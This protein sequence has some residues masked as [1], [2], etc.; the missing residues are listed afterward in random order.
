MLTSDRMGPASTYLESECSL[1]FTD[2]IEVD[3]LS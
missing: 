1:S 3:I 2:M